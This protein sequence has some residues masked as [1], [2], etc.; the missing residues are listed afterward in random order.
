MA[1]R[2][3]E[4]AERTWKTTAEKFGADFDAKKRNLATFRDRHDELG[5]K[6]VRERQGLQSRAHEVQL[7]LFLQQSFISDHKIPDI[8]RGRTAT[9]TSYG[10]ETAADIVEAAVLDVPGFGRALASRLLEWRRTIES[11]FVFN[12]SVGIPPPQQQALDAKYARD[13]QQLEMSLLSGERELVQ[14]PPPRI[15]SL[16]S[17]TVKLEQR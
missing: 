7:D 16:L 14:S 3:L 12:A 13:R 10:I 1:Q 2:K 15:R 9:L 6:Y 4:N 8:G 5:R 17:T 11:Q